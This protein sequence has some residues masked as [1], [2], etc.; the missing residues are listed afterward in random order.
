MNYKAFCRTSHVYT[1]ECLDTLKIY[2]KIKDGDALVK[3]GTKSIFKV[4]STIS[5]LKT[6]LE[7]AIMAK[8]R[9]ATKNLSRGRAICYE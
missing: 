5:I 8:G 9:N 7:C 3:H 6:T 4:K 1:N 2:V